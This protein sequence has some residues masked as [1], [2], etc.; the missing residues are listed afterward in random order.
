MKSRTFSSNIESREG[1][2]GLIVI[3]LPFLFLLLNGC[4]AKLAVMGG[5]KHDTPQAGVALSFG[6]LP[7]ESNWKLNAVTGVSTEKF[8]SGYD[9]FLELGMQLRYTT[10]TSPFGFGSELVYINDVTP[11]SFSTWDISPNA[12]G[13]S[14]GAFGGYQMPFKKVDLSAFSKVSYV[15]FGNDSMNDNIKQPNNNGIKI[16]FGLEIALPFQ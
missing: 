13:I 7:K 16:V 3:I 6:E 2:S 5:F 1:K 12:N 15:A 10:N 14:I 11:N 9:S 8:E 4:A